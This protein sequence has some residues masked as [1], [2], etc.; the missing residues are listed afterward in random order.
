MHRTEEDLANGRAH[1]HN[2]RYGDHT[3]PTGVGY[4]ASKRQR[5]DPPLQVRRRR[6]SKLP[7][8]Y[9]LCFN[10]DLLGRV[11]ERNYPPVLP[12]DF[13]IWK[14]QINSHSR[15]FDDDDVQMEDMGDPRYEHS[16]PPGGGAPANNQGTEDASGW[17]GINRGNQGQQG[18]SLENASAWDGI[19][20]QQ[21]AEDASKWSGINRQQCAEDASKW[22]GINRAT[23][24]QEQQSRSAA[25]NGERS[26]QEDESMLADD[27]EEFCEGSCIWEYKDSAHRRKVRDQRSDFVRASPNLPS[28]AKAH[29]PFIFKFQEFVCKR[30]KQTP[31]TAATFQDL[32][33]V[34]QVTRP[35]RSPEPSLPTPDASP[36]R[37][38]PTRRTKRPQEASDDEDRCFDPVKRDSFQVRLHA[39]L[40]DYCDMTLL[41]LTKVDPRPLT[42]PTADEIE[43][44]RRDPRLAPGPDLASL[45]LDLKSTNWE[46]SVW[47]LAAADMIADEFVQDEE[48]QCKNKRMV[49]EAFRKHLRQL[50]DR[51]R[52]Q[53]WQR[54]N[55]K[56]AEVNEA[57]SLRN[58]RRS[59]RRRSLR[60][61]RIKG[62]RA[63]QRIAAKTDQYEKLSQFEKLLSEMPLDAMSGDESDHGVFVRKKLP[64]RS[65]DTK[66]LE[67]FRVL[68][69]LYLSTRFADNDKPIPGAFPAQRLLPNGILYD[70]NPVPRLPINLYDPAYLNGLDEYGMARLAPQK[71]IDL[72]FPP[73]LQL[74]AARFSGVHSGNRKPLPRDHPSLRNYRS[75]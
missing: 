66:V 73:Q 27:E 62:I 17:G 11:S 28:S 31:N 34:M 10:E 7:P 51:Y 40:R 3:P 50:R 75:S 56:E 33:G 2:K 65:P 18:N 49:R 41:Q 4:V 12:G 39:E 16:I 25:R 38:K 43:K 55:D 54:T 1:V 67:W 15:Y 9:K 74:V 46:S 21:C 36:R 53:E 35:L 32:L 26:H 69:G 60:E 52:R 24:S 42:T 47:N 64:W 5:R 30:L 45:R 63:Y 13:V 59:N 70:A 20:G 68:D 44:F 48:Y 19:N 6:R 14:Q 29:P 22:G 71:A 72:S 23:R 57:R 37:P 8:Y 58:L 61:R